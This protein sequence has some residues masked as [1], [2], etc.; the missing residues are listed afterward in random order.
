M[1]RV[2]KE[3]TTATKGVLYRKIGGGSLRID[4]KIIKPNQTFRIDPDKIPS[5]FK[6]S[7]ICLEPEKESEIT[8]IPMKKII[9]ETIYEKFPKT[10]KG[11][12]GVRRVEDGKEISTK[13]MKEEAADALI[14]KLNSEE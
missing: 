8:E 11:W 12:F 3:T 6:K 1:E 13:S 2:K 5:A 14:E 4:G 9:D 7:L 10:A